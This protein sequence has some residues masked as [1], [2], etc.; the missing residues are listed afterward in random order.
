MTYVVQHL[1][2]VAHIPY[3][4][5][6]GTH[7]YQ[8]TGK[9]RCLKGILHFS[10]LCQFKTNSY[11]RQ[12]NIWQTLRS[13]TTLI[14]PIRYWLPCKTSYPTDSSTSSDS[15]PCTFTSPQVESQT[16]LI[17][18]VGPQATKRYAPTAAALLLCMH[19][20]PFSSCLPELWSMMNT[21]TPNNF[22]A[23]K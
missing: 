16:S 14:Y 12:I 23:T 3:F 6:S 4:E 17:L 21:V 22:L 10:T 1:L 11:C 13:L 9:G 7:K 8:M 19:L 15:A 2:N 20:A 5:A 18:S